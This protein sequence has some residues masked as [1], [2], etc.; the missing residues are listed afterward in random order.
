MAELEKA[1]FA[2][3]CFWGPEARFGAV[4]GVKTTRVGYAGGEKED[5]TYHDLGDHTESVQLDYDSDKVG[6]EELLEIFWNSHDY[7]RRRKTQYRSIAF[8]HND[9]QKELIEET[10]PEDT[11][12]D[13]R[14]MEKLYLAEDYHQ[15]YRLRN[16]EL[17]ERFEGLT[18]EELIGS[19]EAG[20][21][22]R[23]P[24]GT[25]NIWICRVMEAVSISKMY[26][27]V[28]Y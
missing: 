21:Q 5:P 4:E 9:R 24:Q 3:G 28:T 7:N 1:T 14:P 23:P 6:F 18:D 22:T 11:V 10:R 25:F 13:I 2:L 20:K 8:Y 19:P 16:S 27:L 12:T 17:F 26:F 15:K